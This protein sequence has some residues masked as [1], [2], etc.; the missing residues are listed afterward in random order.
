[1]VYRSPKAERKPL[2]LPNPVVVEVE[3]NA[4]YIGMP[5]YYSIISYLI[6]NSFPGLAIQV[7]PN[8]RV[9]VKD[10]RPGGAIDRN[11]FIKVNKPGPCE[12]ILICNYTIF[13]L[14][15][16]F[17]ILQVDNIR[18]HGK[19]YHNAARE[20]ADT[21]KMEGPTVQFIV[22]PNYV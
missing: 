11:N 1:M 2:K 22:I 4:P 3:K 5:Y 12:A 7:T 20:I 17:E 13:P 10:V 16:G 9:I 19:S 14:Q 21:F 18:V 15:P 6:N 8:K